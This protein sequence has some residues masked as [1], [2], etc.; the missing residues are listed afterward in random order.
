M[1]L[2]LIQEI[3]EDLLIEESDPLEV[4]PA[5]GLEAHDLVDQAVRLMTQTSDVL[6]PLHLLAH[7]GGVVADLELDGV[8][9][10]RLHLL[11]PLNRLLNELLRLLFRYLPLEEELTGAYIYRQVSNRL[12]TMLD[13]TYAC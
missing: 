9:G 7:V 13:T 10:G 6:L 5:A 2:V 12:R 3:V 11:Q 4:V 8:E 1:L